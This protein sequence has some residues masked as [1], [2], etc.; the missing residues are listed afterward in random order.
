M[1]LCTRPWKSTPIPMSGPTASRTVATLCTQRST[2]SQES[3]NCISAVPFILT[4]VNPRSTAA[5]AAAAVSA[6]RSPP[7]QE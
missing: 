5:R 3:T 2:L 6:G 4:A 1:G 7:I